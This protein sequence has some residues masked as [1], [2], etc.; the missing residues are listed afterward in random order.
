MSD[1]D[2]IL[3]EEKKAA[4]LKE[5]RRAL[6]MAREDLESKEPETDNLLAQ[7][8][9]KQNKLLDLLN[10]Q[11]RHFETEKA[12]LNLQIQ[13]LTQ[14]RDESVRLKTEAEE[15]ARAA[16]NDKS[17]AE[18]RS[19]ELAAENAAV[20]TSVETLLAEK[21]ELEGEA[22]AYLSEKA[23]LEKT[24]ETLLAEKS[25]LETTVEALTRGKEAAE[26]KVA[27]ALEENTKMEKTLFEAVEALERQKGEISDLKTE[28]E[29]A[30]QAAREA[31]RDRKSIQDKLDK[32]QE[33]WTRMMENQ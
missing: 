2:R 11:M 16:L 9:T 27:A 4:L 14:E 24:A 12:A 3:A 1:P 20:K 5:V 28:L 19:E 18:K 15:Q 29:K 32:F 10:S 6:E 25:V 13:D 23:A 21:T 30:I 22:E 8:E 7:A 17:S 33:N 26:E 31:D